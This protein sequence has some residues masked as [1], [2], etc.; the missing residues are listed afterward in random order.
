MLLFVWTS[1]ESGCDTNVCLTIK[2]LKKMKN[3]TTAPINNIYFIISGDIFSSPF[4][5]SIGADIFV[6]TSHKQPIITLNIP[7]TPILPN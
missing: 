1:L 5:S 7:A 4:Y 2:L 3:A 6:L